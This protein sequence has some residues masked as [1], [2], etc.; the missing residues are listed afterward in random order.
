M[1]KNN[2]KLD[3]SIRKA[4]REKLREYHKDTLEKI[5]ASTAY[6]VGKLF[7]TPGHKKSEGAHNELYVSLFESEISKGEDVYLEQTNTAEEPETTTRT[8][9]KYRY[10]P[11]F[12]EEYELTPNRSDSWLV[13]VEELV[14][15]IVPDEAD[16]KHAKKRLSTISAAAGINT[17]DAPIADMTIRDLAAILLK[18]PVSQKEWLNSLIKQV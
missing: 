6:L 13:P 17:E 4:N 14:K 18:K 3:P 16:K 5:G 2:V 9:Y 1:I 11:N 15:V 12:K 10:N 7:Y 8:L